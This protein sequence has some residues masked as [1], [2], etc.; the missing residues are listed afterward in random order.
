[1]K[2]SQWMSGLLVAATAV[3]ALSCGN[4]K[5]PFVLGFKTAPTALI[6]AGTTFPVEVVLNKGDNTKSNAAGVPVTLSLV[7]PNAANQPTD[8]VLSGTLTVESKDGV[9]SFPDL[10]VTRAAAGYA[11]QATSDG[12]TSATSPTFLIYAASPQKLAIVQQ[13]ADGSAGGVVNPPPQ[14]QV[15]DA[16]GNLTKTANTTVRAAL[17]QNPNGA[18]LSGTTSVPTTEAV[19]EFSELSI[20]K[21]G[22]GYT[23]VFS[24]DSLDPVESG[25]ITVHSGPTTQLRFRTQPSSTTGGMPIAPEVAVEL[26]DSAGN[27]TDESLTTVS[28]ALSGGPTGAHLSGTTAVANHGVAAFPDLTVDLAGSGYVLTASAPNTQAVQ[29]SAFN[30]TVGPPA[31]LAFLVQPWDTIPSAAIAPPVQVAVLDRGGNPTTAAVPITVALD[32]NPT[33]ATLTG[34]VTQSSVSGVATFSG[35]AVSKTGDNFTLRASSAGLTDAV[36]GGFLVSTTP[37]SAVKFQAQ[38]TGAST[39]AVLAP[40]TV[41]VVD[42][43]NVLIPTNNVQITLALGS[44]SGGGTLGGTLTRRASAGVATFNDLTVSAPGTY[45]LVATA[46]GLTSDTSSAFNMTAPTLVYTDP[47]GTAKL[48][49]VKDAASTSSTIVLDLVATQTL[50]GYSVGFD[51]PLDASRVQLAGG[52]VAGKAGSTPLNP[53]TNPPAQKAALPTSGPLAGVLVSGLSQK[54]SGNGAVLND[55]S[56]TTGAV[57]YQVQLQLKPG[58]RAGVVFDGLT[59]LPS[60]FRAALR[61][62]QGNEVASASD[63]AVGRLELQ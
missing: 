7:P 49:L 26:L 55:A 46:S 1:M 39:A 21:P 56:I 9:A 47:S 23:L 51:L 22:S 25:A 58:G 40:V 20:D 17:G 8:G 43:S 31:K 19:A 54:A 10:T 18:T 3:S 13:P 60:G 27:L 36:S 45:T 6:A 2:P 14:I 11:I 61:D 50:A 62:R 16:Y 35:L 33:G 30:V 41:R 53:G 34:T 63:F 4:D 59:S 57:L 24:G 5:G 42:A 32:T 28:L 44:N 29:S 48:R 12:S 37:A 38:P 15:T 52:L